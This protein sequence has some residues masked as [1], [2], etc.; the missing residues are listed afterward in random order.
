MMPAESS[1][2]WDSVDSQRSISNG[3]S[4]SS[5]S[6]RRNYVDPWDLENYVYIRRHSIAAMPQKPINKHH[7]HERQ[8]MKEQRTQ[9][10]YW[11][12]SLVHEPGYDAPGFVEELY[13]GASRTSNNACH[14]H[15]PIYEVDVPDY[16]APVPLYAPLSDNSMHHHP[17]ENEIPAV[18]STEKKERKS[19]NVIPPSRLDLN[20]YGYLKIDYAN[21]WN[22]LRLKMHK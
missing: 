5:G 4:G 14:Y 15:R 8:L 3:S 20:T 9:S 13:C 11:C 16:V 12:D 1:I 7:R 6:G 22:S 18:F 17:Q 2:Y 19:N 10:H 21:S